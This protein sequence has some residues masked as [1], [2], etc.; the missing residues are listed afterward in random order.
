[1][2]PYLLPAALIALTLPASANFHLW[3]IN[4]V[5]SNADGSVQFIELFCAS[6]GQEVL[7][8]HTL[9]FRTDTT[10]NNSFTFLTNSGTPTGGKS[11]LVGT[12]NLSAILGVTPDFIISSQFFAAGVNNTINFENGTDAVTLSSLPVNGIGSLDALA[13]NSTSSA[14]GINTFATPTNF[15]GQTATVPEPSTVCLLA[16]GLLAVLSRRRKALR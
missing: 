6:N 10:I 8:G 14:F 5:Y 4:E 3:D 9:T 16:G 2:K 1:M 13:S 7:A 11:L 15:A 12:A